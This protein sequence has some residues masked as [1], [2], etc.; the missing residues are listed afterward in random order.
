VACDH[1]REFTAVRAAATAAGLTPTGYV[2]DAALAAASGHTPPM[3]EPMREVLLELMAARAQVRRFGVNVNQAVRELNSTG[4]APEWLANAVALTNRAVTRL[5]STKPLHESPNICD[6]PAR[7]R[8]VA[9]IRYRNLH[10]SCCVDLPSAEVPIRSAS[11][12]G[13]DCDD[14]EESGG[15]SPGLHDLT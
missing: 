9:G 7:T 8:A 15:Y 11:G 10:R 6:N 13:E 5:D 12:D 4:T 14:G 2:A 1:S 3:A